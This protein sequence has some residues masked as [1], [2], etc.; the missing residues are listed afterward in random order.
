MQIPEKISSQLFVVALSLYAVQFLSADIAS[1]FA[2][3]PNFKTADHV[4]VARCVSTETREKTQPDKFGVHVKRL[5]A[6]FRVSSVLKGPETWHEPK[7]EF[8]AIEIADDD[9]FS[10]VDSTDARMLH[11]AIERMVVY[12]TDRSYMIFLKE[13]KLLDSIEVPTYQR[14]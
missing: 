14:P 8:S 6:H 13:G 3:G 9:K 12:K 10:K 1:P 7:V 11:G 4:L 2:Y 5:T